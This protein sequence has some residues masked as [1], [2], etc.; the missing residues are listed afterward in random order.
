MDFEKAFDRGE[1][2][3][4]ASIMKWVNLG[5]QII[6]WVKIL[7]NDFKLATCNNGYTSRYFVP[8]RGLF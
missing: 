7:F 5:E 8:T 6:E 3:A 1:Y 2:H 4:I